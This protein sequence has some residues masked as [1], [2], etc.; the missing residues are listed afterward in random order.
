VAPAGQASGRARQRVR[1]LL[2]RRIFCRTARHL[3]CMTPFTSAEVF[4]PKGCKNCRVGV[5]RGSSKEV[6][7]AT[8]NVSRPWG[9]ALNSAPCAFPRLA[10]RPRIIPAANNRAARCARY[11]PDIQRPC[12]GA[13]SGLN[14]QYLSPSCE[15]SIK[16]EPP[17]AGLTGD[18]P[19]DGFVSA[20]E[21]ELKLL[22]K[23]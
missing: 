9:A 3:S 23:I 2:S 8:L 7:E 12:G 22:C 13:C 11:E 6:A 1:I 5:S 21:F 18:R 10:S 4:R 20:S 15:V 19:R 14:D 16:L 17:Q